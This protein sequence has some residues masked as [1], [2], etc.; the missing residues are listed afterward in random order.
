MFKKISLFLAVTI[1]LL[2]VVMKIDANE[3]G[4]RS[5]RGFRNV[6]QK[7]AIENV[8]QPQTNDP[9]KT[10]EIGKVITEKAL[11]VE[12]GKYY[13]AVNNKVCEVNL[14]TKEIKAF[15]EELPEISG[16]FFMVGADGQ[17]YEIEDS[18]IS[19]SSNLRIDGLTDSD[20]IRGVKSAKRN[21]S[22][23]KKTLKSVS[24]SSSRKSARGTRSVAGVSEE[25]TAE[26]ITKFSVAG[27][28]G[29]VYAEKCR[30]SAVSGHRT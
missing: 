20:K 24:K 21:K 28:D 14:T 19:E 12:L 3:R 9:Q 26:S 18:R 11:P 7:A 17:I 23:K 25:T 22:P 2:T 15:A 10:T 1:L 8:E 4:S 5:K 27:K 29:Y 13:F 16:S 6:E 30:K